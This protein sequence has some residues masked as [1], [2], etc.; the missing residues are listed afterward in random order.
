MRCYKKKYKD[1]IGRRLKPS[2]GNCE[3]RPISA[4]KNGSTNLKFTC[5]SS[6]FAAILFAEI[7]R[8]SPLPEPGSMKVDF[9]H[10]NGN[11]QIKMDLSERL[12]K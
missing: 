7:G 9:I 8:N 1:V 2:S 6:I 10:E 12:R 3:F 4:S 5:K 11:L